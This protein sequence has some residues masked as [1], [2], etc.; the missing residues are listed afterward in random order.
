MLHGSHGSAAGL[1]KYCE[2]AAKEGIAV[3]VPESR[4]QTWDR[5]KGSFGAD[6]A[7]L[8]RVLTYTFDRLTIN[9][10]RLAIAG[11]S[12]GASYALSVGLSNG[13]LFSHVIAYSPE[14][15]SAPVRFGKPSVFIAHGVQDPVLSV[16]FSEQMVRKLKGSGYVV[17]F[18]EFTGGHM[19]RPD[20]V[21]ESF[22]WFLR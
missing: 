11:F 13:D 2:A 9:P 8:D 3:A 20:L 18:R 6:V 21:K 19:M 16:N 10:Q 12:D 17:E 4:G 5:I 7:F 22:Q 15:I 14:F 1:V